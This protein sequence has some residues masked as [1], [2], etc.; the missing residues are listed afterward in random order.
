MHKNRIIDIDNRIDFE[1]AEALCK[2][3]EDKTLIIGA[4]TAGIC[5]ANELF[6]KKEDFEIFD[7]AEY[8]NYPSH[9]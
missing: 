2:R 4:G 8:K 1:L 9:L 5:I 6:K 7:T 3:N